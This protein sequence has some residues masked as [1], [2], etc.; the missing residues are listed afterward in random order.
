MTEPYIGEIR[1][2]GFNFAPRGWARCEGQLLPIAQNSAL[3]SLLGTSYGGNGTTN[4]LLPDFRARAPVHAGSSAG[5]GLQQW[6]TGQA[7][8]TSTVTLLLAQMAQHNHTFLATTN[9]AT[10]TASAN[11]QVAR[12]S[13]GTLLSSQNAKMYS[14]GTPTQSL[15]PTAISQAGGSQPHN[16]MMPYLGLNFCIALQGIFPPRS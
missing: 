3:F 16:N 11:A 14:T 1:I 6:V 4:F 12:A 7:Q 2:F 15:S 10:T 8:G 13:K 5:P 9:T